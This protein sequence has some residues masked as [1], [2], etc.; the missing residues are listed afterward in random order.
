MIRSAINFTACSKKARKYINTSSHDVWVYTIPYYNIRL[1]TLTSQ[2]V[3]SFCCAGDDSIPRYTVLCWT[4]T[5]RFQRTLLNAHGKSLY[6]LYAFGTVHGKPTLAVTVN[7]SFTVVLPCVLSL[8]RK[9]SKNAK[10][11]GLLSRPLVL[12]WQRNTAAVVLLLLLRVL[13]FEISVG[14]KRGPAY[15]RVARWLVESVIRAPHTSHHLNHDFRQWD[16]S[17]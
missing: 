8:P 3:H 12:L 16:R 10:H 13:K 4:V 6:A 7:L 11:S 5:M 17:Q 14:Y 2:S 15:A 1:K 9:A